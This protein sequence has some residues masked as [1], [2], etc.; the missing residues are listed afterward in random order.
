MAVWTRIEADF[1]PQDQFALRRDG[2]ENS[3]GK[4]MDRLRRK[5]E[6]DVFPEELHRVVMIIV[7]RHDEERYC[8]G[9]TA[10]KGL[11]LFGE[12]LKECLALNR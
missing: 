3:L 4:E 9:K 6:T 12:K 5:T 1:V 8:C 11:H 2:G 7:A 10:R